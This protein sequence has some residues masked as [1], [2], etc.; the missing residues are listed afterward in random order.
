MLLVEFEIFLERLL[1]VLIV[2]DVFVDDVGQVGQDHV[3]LSHW[4]R[5]DEIL[6]NFLLNAAHTNYL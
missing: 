1:D 2:E 6:H 5:L 3:H 4:R